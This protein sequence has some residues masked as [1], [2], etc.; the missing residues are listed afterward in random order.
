MT[1]QYVATINTPG[2]L[3]ED[4]PP[5]FDTAREAWFYL[6]QES[7]RAWDGAMMDGAPCP[8]CNDEAESHGPLGLCDDDD[9]DSR[10]LGAAAR[11]NTPGTVYTR[12]PGYDGAHDLGRAYCV[13]EIDS[14]ITEGN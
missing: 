12:T 14:T 4:E 8:V 9:E 6:Y 2:Y 3:P 1:T 7:I 5:I 10:A 11:T 13:T